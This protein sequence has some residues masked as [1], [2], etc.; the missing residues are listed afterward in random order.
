MALGAES[1]FAFSGAGG[2]LSWVSPE[3]RLVVVTRWLDPAWHDR[4]LAAIRAL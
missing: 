3:E 4:V 1:C 2:N